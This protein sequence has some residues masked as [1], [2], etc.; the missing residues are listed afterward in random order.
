MRCERADRACRG[1]LGLERT[2]AGVGRGVEVELPTRAVPV[3]VPVGTALRG[4]RSRGVDCQLG[5][6]AVAVA[7]EDRGG[8]R[9]DHVAL[10]SEEPVADAIIP[11]GFGRDDLAGDVG[12]RGLDVAAAAIR[13]GDGSVE[14]FALADVR[15]GEEGHGRAPRHGDGLVPLGL[16]PDVNGGRDGLDTGVDVGRVRGVDHLGAVTGVGGVRGVGR[17]AGVLVRG[18]VVAGAGAG[19]A[20]G[21][22]GFAGIAT[23]GRRHG[24]DGAGGGE[25]EEEERDEVLGHDGS[26]G[27]G[28]SDE[29][30]DR[31]TPLTRSELS[32][33]GS[34]T[35]TMTE[36]K[37]SLHCLHGLDLKR[38]QL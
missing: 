10:L 31:G 5:E 26:Y 30:V 14:P 35:Q 4:V 15:G 6:T 12:D 11:L 38:H 28:V 25:D 2:V 21:V 33:V 32:D 37:I 34:E 8:Q 1:R 27:L 20:P 13:V 23:G 24:V 36:V 9:V 17:L 22:L 16:R 3:A 7:D 18:R 19:R 29:N